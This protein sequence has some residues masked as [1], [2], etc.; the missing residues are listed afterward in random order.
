MAAAKDI[1]NIKRLLIQVCNVHN[2]I[3]PDIFIKDAMK[4]STDE[5]TEILNDRRR[6]IIAA[7]DENDALIG[8]AFC[9]FKDSASKASKEIKTLYIDDLCVDESMRGMRIGTILFEAAKDLAKENGCYDITLNVWNGNDKAMKF[10]E[11]VGMKPQ[12][13]CMETIL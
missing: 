5:L 9:I 11:S 2:K 10:Y 13:T 12:K 6:P 3:R 4:Y 8:Y 7:V 1:P